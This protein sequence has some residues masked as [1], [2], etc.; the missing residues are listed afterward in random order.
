MSFEGTTAVVTGAAG[1]MGANIVR[2]LLARGARV[3]GRGWRR[4]ACATAD[5]VP[6]WGGR[7]SVT[8]CVSR[9]S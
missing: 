5:R 8:F 9:D 2:D 4:G 1:G 6:A 7:G 3:A